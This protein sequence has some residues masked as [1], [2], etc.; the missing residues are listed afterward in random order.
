MADLSGAGSQQ[1]TVS[2]SKLALT[3][4]I[5]HALQNPTCQVHGILVGKFTEGPFLTIEDAIPA[6]HSAP[7]KPILDMALQ[8]SQ[9]HLQGTNNGESRV[10][11]W[12]TANERWGDDERPGQAALRVIG[13]I[14]SQLDSSELGL[15]AHAEPVL[16]LVSNSE[17]LSADSCGARSAINIFGRDSRK[18]WVRRVSDDFMKIT[19]EG[20]KE[21]SLRTAGNVAIAVCSGNEPISVYDFE[22]HL[23][24]G[25]DAIRS[26]DWLINQSAVELISKIG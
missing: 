6:F 14:A 16:V 17:M 23:D 2:T 20:N 4:M 1:Q 26:T 25:T 18:H 24:G 3:K 19:E 9:A 12:Y 21:E 13:G 15:P 22:D 5:L 11:G 8:I 7:T 10:V